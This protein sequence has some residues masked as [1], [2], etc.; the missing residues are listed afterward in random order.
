MKCAWTVQWHWNCLQPHVGLSKTIMRGASS[1][2]ARPKRLGSMTNTECMA[3]LQGLAYALRQDSSHPED[4]NLLLVVLRVYGYALRHRLFL[5]TPRILRQWVETFSVE[6]VDEALLSESAEW[7][8]SHRKDAS[9]I[10][11]GARRSVVHYFDKGINPFM[12]DLPGF[13]RLSAICE[14]PVR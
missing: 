4:L 1:S 11:V 10:L 5:E 14:P 8:T 12:R 9:C 7:Y 6:Q 13:N 3:A 2:I